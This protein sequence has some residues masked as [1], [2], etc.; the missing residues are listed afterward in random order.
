MLNPSKVVVLD[1]AT[2]S[3][4]TA[5]D[6]RVQAKLKSPQFSNRTVITIAHRIG[7][8]LDYDRILSLERGRVVEFG[9]PAELIQRRGL[10]YSL[11]KEARLVE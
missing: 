9:S 2:A 4:D 10:F 8:V 3:M 5:T 7:T 1:E 11:A 6:E